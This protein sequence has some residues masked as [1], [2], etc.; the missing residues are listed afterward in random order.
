MKVIKRSGREVKLDEKKIVDAIK[1]A[2]ASI[3]E[4]DQISD[5]QI[6]QITKEVMT[7]ISRRKRASH[8]EEIQDLTTN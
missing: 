8:V 2:N 7:R 4:K 3:D 6:A 1:N 5:E